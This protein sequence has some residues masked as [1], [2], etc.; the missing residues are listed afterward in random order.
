MNRASI[1]KS[2]IYTFVVGL[3][4]AVTTLGTEAA[5]P[6][7]IGSIDT[8]PIVT[9]VA[10]NFDAYPPVRPG[11]SG[12]PTRDGDVITTR[13]D[14]VDFT[15]MLGFQARIVTPASTQSSPRA[16]GLVKAAPTS[17]GWTRRTYLSSACEL[18]AGELGQTPPLLVQFASARRTVTL[19]TGFDGTTEVPLRAKLLVS[20]AVGSTE[21]TTPLTL[22]G[23]RNRITVAS[24]GADGKGDIKAVFV[25]FQATVCKSGYVPLPVIDSLSASGS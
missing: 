10:I 7:A 8:D 21:V 14:G 4:L 6:I 1:I 5:E 15:Q 24:T 23:V 13:F 18:G 9:G 20:R 3:L 25:S 19:Y 2:G 22:T 17:L 16:L 11:L 12:A